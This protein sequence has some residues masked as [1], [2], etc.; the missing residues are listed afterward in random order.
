M[1]SEF[2]GRGWRFPI[3]PD[4]SGG[5]GFVEGEEN[6]EQSL[7]IVLLTDMGQ[8]VM[9]PD[10]G[11]KA[12][13]LVFAPGSV[14]FLHLLETTVREAVR[15]WEPRVELDDVL[16]EV[17]PE[18]ETVVIVSINYRVRRTNTR[19]NLVFPFYLGTLEQI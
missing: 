15:D 5:L 6:I 8:R 17:R 7:R 3:L 16:A 14:Q 2:L 13:R 19:N 4:D 9:R 1:E 11:C 18:D 12:P 10:F